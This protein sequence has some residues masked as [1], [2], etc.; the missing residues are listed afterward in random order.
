MIKWSPH[1]KDEMFVLNFRDQIKFLDV[2]APKDNILKH[3]FNAPNFVET[4]EWHPR[5]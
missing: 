5:Q 1:S 2:F 4:G 3:T